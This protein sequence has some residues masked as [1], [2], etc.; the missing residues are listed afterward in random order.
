[1]AEVENEELC[2][3]AEVVVGV[4]DV[5]EGPREGRV[6]VRERLVRERV[7]WPRDPLCGR[8]VE[9]CLCVR[10]DDIEGVEIDVDAK[11]RV[12]CWCRREERR[13]IRAMK[14]GVREGIESKMHFTTRPQ[15]RHMLDK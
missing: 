3:R 9:R 7:S 13:L 15:R 14:L 6:G 1:V 5:V 11:A 8:G 10:R 2:W 12:L 4:M